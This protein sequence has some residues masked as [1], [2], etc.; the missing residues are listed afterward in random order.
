MYRK[1]FMLSTLTWVSCVV[2]Q[3]NKSQNE[4]RQ[5]PLRFYVLLCVPSL[6]EMLFPGLKTSGPVLLPVGY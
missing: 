3:I 2:E 5:R 1:I 4:Q 6:V